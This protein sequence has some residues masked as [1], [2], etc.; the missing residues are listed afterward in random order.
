MNSVILLKKSKDI[1]D[2]HPDFHQ[3]FTPENELNT[4]F[5]Y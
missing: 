3:W 5:K 1:T 2:F 4:G